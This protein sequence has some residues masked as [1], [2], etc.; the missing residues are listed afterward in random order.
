MHRAVPSF[1]TW[2]TTKPFGDPV[3][4]PSNVSMICAARVRAA[5]DVNASLSLGAS[6]KVAPIDGSPTICFG[7]RSFGPT[8]NGTG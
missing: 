4:S 2:T 7:K 8:L 6:T 3:P 1:S 5:T